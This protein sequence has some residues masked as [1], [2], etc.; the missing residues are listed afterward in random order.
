MEATLADYD[1]RVAI[2][3]EPQVT[4]AVLETR[5]L[6]SALGFDATA[7]SLITTT[8]SELAHNIRKYADH[9]EIILRRV[10]QGHQTGIEVVASDQGPGIGDLEAALSDHWSTSG[11]LGLGLP[12][13]KRMMD[14]F[15]VETEPSSG[16]RVTVRKWL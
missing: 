14:E 16:T 10:R 7:A 8:V 6:A 1:V 9:G 15:Q 13:V 4:Q 5:R 12:G 2:S 11:T 3:G